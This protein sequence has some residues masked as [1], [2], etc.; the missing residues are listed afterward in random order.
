MAMYLARVVGQLALSEVAEIFGRDR[1]TVSHGCAN[2]ADRRDS[3]LFDMQ[4]EY[5]EKRLRKRIRQYRLQN[6]DA[7]ENSLERKK[8][9]RKF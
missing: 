8:I 3:P 5:K 9:V 4:M 1:S 7:K 2:I 6:P